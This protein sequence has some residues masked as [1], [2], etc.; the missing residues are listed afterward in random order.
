MARDR[1]K[2]L[3]AEFPTVG[4]MKLPPGIESEKLNTLLIMYRTHCQRIVDTV[5]RANFDD[6]RAFLV[7]FWQGFPSHMIDLL[8]SDYVV[9]V[10]AVCDGLVYQSVTK[11][12]VPT[13]TNQLPDSLVQALANFADDFDSCLQSAL[14]G[15]PS[16]LCSTKLERKSLLTKRENL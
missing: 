13:L 2:T 9:M 8:K 15:L 6:V 10:L 4:E 5:T 12:L 16:T 1:Q 14:R 11:I 3:L 7:H